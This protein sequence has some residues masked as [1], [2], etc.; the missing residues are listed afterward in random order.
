MRPARRQHIPVRRGDHVT[1]TVERL[2]DGPDGLA[3]IGDYIVFVPGVL[4]GERA[5]VEITSATR[6]YGRARLVTLHSTSPERVEP[7]CEHFLECGGCHL[8]HQ[9]YDGQLRDKQARLQ[10][11]IEHALGEH[12]PEVAPTVA[13]LQPYGQRYKVVVHL[14]NDPRYGLSAALRRQRSLD[15][16]RIR[17]CPASTPPAMRL[18][19]QAVRLLRELGHHAW[20]PDFARDGLLRT[21]LV[22]WSTL[23]EAHLVL[24]ARVAKI[25]GVDRI[26]DDLHATGASTIS[27][28]HNEG[29]ASRLLGPE[30]LVLSGEPRILEQIGEFQYAISPTSF[31]QTSPHMAERI[32]QHVVD[33]LAPREDQVVADLY[34]GGGLLTLPLALRAKHAIG[35]DLSARAIADARSAAADNRVHNI[36]WRSGHVGSWLQACHSGDLP[37]PELLA[38][39][40]PRTGLDEDTI[41]A[42]AQLQPARLA[43]VSCDPLSLQRDLVALHAVGFETNALTGFDMFPQTG[44]IESVACLTRRRC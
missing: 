39:D 11:T 24:V 1:V 33:W 19:L 12:A 2:G 42:L 6:K 16:V 13:N 10:R 36:T 7:R 22:R 29:E 31:F 41:A 4:P 35:I 15:L 40:P 37:R 25:P 20:D 28:N 3:R 34:C 32:V 21:V 27:I 9:D 5:T 23:D 17:E 38:M 26:L 8:Q 44:H 43:Y 14:Y 18:A 30:T